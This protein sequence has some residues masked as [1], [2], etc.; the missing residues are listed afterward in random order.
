MNYIILCFQDIDPTFE[1][2]YTFQRGTTK[3]IFS[4]VHKYH[5]EPLIA[6]KD[7][8]YENFYCI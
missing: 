1:I 8:N 7:R 2:L 5:A 4:Y 6:N 3:I